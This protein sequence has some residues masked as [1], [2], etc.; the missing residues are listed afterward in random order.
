MKTKFQFLR[1]IGLA[2]IKRM[3]E[4]KSKDAQL[5]MLFRY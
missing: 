5:W 4:W 1:Q 3:Y 2:F